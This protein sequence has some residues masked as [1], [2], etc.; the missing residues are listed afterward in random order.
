MKQKNLTRVLN[1]LNSPFLKAGEE[2]VKALNEAIA[3]HGP[4]KSIETIMEGTRQALI[5]LVIEEFEG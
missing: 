1:A 3:A 2:A 4:E 5:E